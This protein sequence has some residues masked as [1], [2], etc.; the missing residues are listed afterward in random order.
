VTGFRH[1]SFIAGCL[2]VGALHPGVIRKSLMSELNTRDERALIKL[3][4]E[5]SAST[6]RSIR[7]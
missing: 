3:L 7:R 5:G 1:T 6:R 2:T 4:A